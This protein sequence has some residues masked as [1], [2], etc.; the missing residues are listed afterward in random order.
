MTRWIFFFSSK[1]AAILT[2][3]EELP[4]WSE[5]ACDPGSLFPRLCACLAVGGRR[6]GKSETLAASGPLLSPAS[7]HAVTLWGTLRATEQVHPS[8]RPSGMGS[9]RKFACLSLAGLSLLA[10]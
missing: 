8:P 1:E 9:Q 7:S 10:G 5:S 2:S 6:A 4:L 3:W